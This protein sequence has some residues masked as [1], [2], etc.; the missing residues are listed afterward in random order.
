MVV[1][2]VVVAVV[3]FNTLKLTHSIFFAQIV[4]LSFEQKACFQLVMT[5]DYRTGRS[6]IMFNYGSIGWSFW[7]YR[8]AAQGYQDRNT[9]MRL[10]T[11]YRYLSYSLDTLPG[12]TGE[13]LKLK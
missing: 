1:V 11:S 7:N 12:N 3:V 10:H 4:L 5:N 8:T 2:I 13:N 6:Y 9:Y